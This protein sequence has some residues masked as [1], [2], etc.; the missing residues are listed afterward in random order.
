MFKSNDFNLKF[1]VKLSDDV[2]GIVNMW[3]RQL[4]SGEI[5]QF[6][7]WIEFMRFH[8]WGCNI[9][10][11]EHGKPGTLHSPTLNGIELAFSNMKAYKQF[12]AD[13]ELQAQIREAAEQILAK[14][15]T[16]FPAQRK[17][18]H[19]EIRKIEAELE[20]ARWKLDVIDEYELLDTLRKITQDD[21]APEGY[22]DLRV[23]ELRETYA[24]SGNLGSLIWDDVKQDINDVKLQRTT[25]EQIM[26][27]LQPAQEALEKLD[28]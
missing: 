10:I 7:N 26:A 19:D 24:G 4:G 28:E 1:P 20:H 8:E 13:A 27:R 18:V 21:D 23:A 25:W 9:S 2:Y 22:F 15:K 6:L 14:A 17:E 12:R 16:S 3:Y 11:D 5:V